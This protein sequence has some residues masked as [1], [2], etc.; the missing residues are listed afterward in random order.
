MTPKG[1]LGDERRRVNPP[2]LLVGVGLLGAAAAVWFGL[3]VTGLTPLRY[4]EPWVAY[5]AA[6]WLAVNTGLILAAMERVR[7]LRFGTELRASVR[8]ETRLR[9]TLDGS[10]CV[11]HDAS[12]A[13]A[14]VS[15]AEGGANGH[16]VAGQPRRL[17][18]DLESAVVELEV[19]T[20]SRRPLGAGRTLC[21]LQFAGGQESEL[22]PLTLALFNGQS[23]RKAVRSGGMRTPAT[24]RQRISGF[25][26]RHYEAR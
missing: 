18:I 20:R 15:L 1:R 22:V 11:I 16:T 7:S 6:F 23:W 3:T 5:G 8:F 14:L 10:P 19:E 13:G 24:A 12:L 26:G 4:G 2:T 25:A 21:A 17:T 9:G